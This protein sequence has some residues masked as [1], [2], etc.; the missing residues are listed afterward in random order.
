MFYFQDVT[1]HVRR[2]GWWVKESFIGVEAMWKWG[3][4]ASRSGFPNKANKS[5]YL[6]KS[7]LAKAEVQDCDW[8][9]LGFPDRCFP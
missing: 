2:K 7:K 1:V 4:W 8:H 9:I 6:V 5:Y 3:R